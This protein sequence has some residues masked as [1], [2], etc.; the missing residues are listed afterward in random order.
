LAD[1]IKRRGNEKIGAAPLYRGDRLLGEGRGHENS[2]QEISK[3]LWG[4]SRAD[5]GWWGRL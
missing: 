2:V 4:F 5:S 1:L 3:N